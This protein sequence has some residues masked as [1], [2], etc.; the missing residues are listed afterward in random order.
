MAEE[1]ISLDN[2]KEAIENKETSVDAESNEA[3]ESNPSAVTSKSGPT[4]PVIDEQGRSYATG[5]RKDAV[6]RVWVKP[7]LGKI[8]VNGREVE[9]YF[10]RPV[11]QMLLNQPLNI[12]DRAGQYVFLVAPSGGQGVWSWGGLHSP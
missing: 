7:G 12:T 11:L 2:L 8:T 10:A 3:H 4:E 6:A 5:K 1:L 9:R